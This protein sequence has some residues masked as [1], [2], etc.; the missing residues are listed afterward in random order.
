MFS[1]LSNGKTS[2]AFLTDDRVAETPP[3]GVVSFIAPSALVKT[4]TQS[5]QNLVFTFNNTVVPIMGT[6]DNDFLSISGITDDSL[7]GLQ[8][9]DTLLSFGGVDLLFG[10]AGHDLLQG[11]NLA[12]WLYGDSGNDSLYGE[13]GWDVLYAANEAVP[14]VDEANSR[15]L[16]VGDAGGDT[17]F[18][19][20]GQDTLYGGNDE[21]FLTGDA[22]ADWLHGGATADKFVVDLS[23]SPATASSFSAADTI[24]DFSLLDGD[25]LSFGLTD[26]MLT[27]PGGPRQLMWRGSLQAPSG[28]VAGF[29]LPGSDLGETYLQ[30]WLLISAPEATARG[31]WIVIDFDQNGVIGAADILFLLQSV[32]LQSGQ[33]FRAVDPASFAGWAGDGQGNVLE[34]RASGSRLFGLGG[35]D[36]LLGGI[37]NDWLSGGDG[38]DTLAGDSGDDQL[39][40]GA[41]DDWL[42]GGN[43]NDALYAFGPGSAENDNAAAVNRL[44]GQAGD[45]SLYGGLGSDWL[46]GGT[47]RDFLYGDDGTGSLEGGSGNDTLLGGN[48]TDSL[49]GDTGTDSIVG[50]GGDD[51]IAYGDHSDRLIGG[52][53]LDWVVTSMTLSFNLS[54]SENQAI[55]GAW[56]AGFEA[57][58]ASASSGS[59]TLLGGMEGNHLISGS[60]SDSLHGNAGDDILQAGLGNDSLAR[61]SGLNI[62]A[63]GA[64]DDLYI[65]DSTDDLALEAYFEGNDS[66]ITACDFYL[67]PEVEVLIL[68]PGSTAIRGGGGL[69]HDRLIGNAN[70]NELLG[71]DGNDT[72]EG[73]N[74]ADTLEGGDQ[75]DILS[76]GDQ[77]DILFGD[78]GH[79]SLHAGASNDTLI[80]G[81]GADTMAGGASDDLYIVDSAGDLVLEAS[82]SG[83]DTVISSVN[84]NLPSG[85]ELLIL[86]P[87]ANQLRGGAN[88]DYLM[89]N[90][91]SNVLW[92]G[93][94]ND[95]LD[96]GEGADTLEG[97]NQDD[98]LYGGAGQDY[99]ESGVGNDTLIG[100]A[101]ADTL[102]GG[103]GNDLYVL[104]D[105]AD[106]ILEAPASGNDTVITMSDLVMPSHIEVLL[107][108]ESASN[109]YLVGRDLDD[110]MIGNGLGHRFE[111]GVGN[112][113][114]LAGGQSLTDMMALFDGWL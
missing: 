68:A 50:G 72:I 75:N 11:G 80:G 84:I 86:T 13:E 77:A 52:S 26:G 88:H 36:V 104:V 34:A 112:D 97:G 103:L 29:V 81:E 22:G 48:G 79:D 85:V 12:D 56:V 91:N 76:G 28:P 60:G 18:G 95:T 82:A 63:A 58:D 99:L 8:G 21:D 37:G 5:A 6:D 106:L 70:A 43:G 49:T 90:A 23:V 92:G 25:S 62:M 89:G 111:G 54:V 87:E 33:I 7:F 101:A 66:I 105:P 73:G 44:E 31:G 41:G 30:A 45:D 83:N 39:W 102:A 100:G 20:I 65:I 38:Q 14:P 94:G 109:L 96:G 51:T 113:V 4:G 3:S 59:V 98:I 10:G 9:D 61:G 15:N 24:A 47:G 69:G 40:G 67:P 32:D 110:I 107:V 35:A 27:G 64:G 71:G 78:A 57:V 19:S 2:Y 42:L 55:N 1:R 93:D 108:G 17:L 114:I 53:G 74:G 16:L 46:I